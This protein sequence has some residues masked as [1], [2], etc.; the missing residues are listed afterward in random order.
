M[1][2]T[3]VVRKVIDNKVD[4]V[5]ASIAHHD[6]VVGASA[7]V[8]APFSPTSTNQS[9]N[10]FTI[11]VPGQNSLW[12]RKLM[13]RTSTTLSWNV[14]VSGT[15]SFSGNLGG[16]PNTVGPTTSGT[17][18]FFIPY[19]YG[20]DFSCT[21]FPFN[22]LVQTCNTQINGSTINCQASQV[23][24][25][26]R[27]VIESNK[28]L[29]QKLTCPTGVT[30]TSL[31]ANAR[32][33]P[34]D[35]L[36]LLSPNDNGSGAPS[37]A[38]FSSF[39]F[40]DCLGVPVF[41]NY[42]CTLPSSDGSNVQI[43]IIT[44]NG[45]T[46]NSASTTAVAA[47]TLSSCVSI[48][49]PGVTLPFSALS[50][51]QKA[52]TNGSV[53]MLPIPFSALS[54]STASG[55]TVYTF[56]VTIPVS[57]ILTTTEPLLF[58]P[59]T[60]NDEEVS[61]TNVQSANI[62][63]TMLPPGDRMTRILRNL[64]NTGR[65]VDYPGAAS[66]SMDM[67]ALIRGLSTVTPLIDNLQYTSSTPFSSPNGA[68]TAY[69]NF[70]SPAL[71]EP[72]PE[73][74]NYPFLQYYPLVTSNGP[75]LNIVDLRDLTPINLNA[76]SKTSGTLT[77]NVITLNTCPDM[78]ALYVVLNP[79]VALATQTPANLSSIVFLT[80]ASSAIGVPVLINGTKTY[81]VGTTFSYGSAPAVTYTITGNGVNASNQYF[82]TVDK[83][84]SVTAG[85]TVAV[86]AYSFTTAPTYSYSDILAVIQNVSITWNN[87]AALM[88]SF[89]PNELIE[90]TASNGLP[91]TNAIALGVANQR[92][93]S[94][95]S[96][97]TRDDQY[98]NSS[99]ESGDTASQVS[100]I[101]TP[102]LLA[103]NKDLPTEA[104]TA[105]GVSGVYTL[106]VTVNVRVSE[107]IFK[108][109]KQYFQ[110]FV[111]P[112]QT[113]YLQLI[114]GGTSAIVSAVAAADKML[115]AP[116][117]PRRTLQGESPHKH[118]LTGGFAFGMPTWAGVQN[119]AGKLWNRA[120]EVA[121]AVKEHALPVAKA[122]Y[123]A[124][125]G[126]VDR[127]KKGDYEGA[128]GDAIHHGRQLYN[129][130][131]ATRKA[132]GAGDMEGGMSLGVSGAGKRLRHY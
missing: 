4:P 36:S 46:T 11:Q 72:I 55:A 127:F 1:A 75:D 128:V 47:I 91:V 126:I 113:Q 96:G 105:P 112:I 40:T 25:V 131:Q 107:P 77:S 29:R 102:I 44:S 84:I 60:Y 13:M 103:I 54:A 41:T 2:Q 23:M 85:D 110:F 89:L 93:R 109:L 88:Q 80:T 92:F 95:V 6:F 64:E 28:D 71:L 101:G 67:C 83:A 7:S 24:P 124:A 39:Q 116:F 51:K 50:D 49:G 69:A 10:E 114:R 61:F 17:N 9:A 12:S 33:G 5:S 129:G 27:R 82:I 22:S 18:Y 62:R 100:T 90:I 98:F 48:R 45:T 20:V 26:I 79:Q 59:F 31:I 120:S 121:N 58:P 30:G 19:R 21:S 122:A 99:A 53:Y 123:E 97:A 111:T 8:W 76:S 125:P 117:A 3:I 42:N 35:E 43:P 65:R 86:T 34:F 32:G 94:S 106:Q 108:D 115:T 63:L 130:A 119:T 15:Y 132:V 56:N 74:L 78:L 70:L 68:I 38:A 73:T 87:N 66:G 52:L 57:G 104:G 14:Q 16:S 118:K 81:P 37:N